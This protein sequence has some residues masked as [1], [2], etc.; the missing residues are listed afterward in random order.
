MSIERDELRRLVDDLP[1]EQVPTA[2]AELRHLTA[3]P[4][5]R[6]WPPAWFGSVTSSRTDLGANHED[7]LAE[8]FGL[9]T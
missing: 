1:D 7:V 9:S 2:I 5:G 4:I 6:S 3:R 8:G